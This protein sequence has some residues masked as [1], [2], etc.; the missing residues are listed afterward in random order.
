M[1]IDETV[2]VFLCFCKI[3]SQAHFLAVGALLVER[4]WDIAHFKLIN[5]KWRRSPDGREERKQ[6]RYLLS[7]VRAS[8]VLPSRVDCN[9]FAFSGQNG[10][11]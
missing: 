6:E 10:V 5:R 1:P 8:R 9:E 11:T 3:F 4:T 2:D 7:R